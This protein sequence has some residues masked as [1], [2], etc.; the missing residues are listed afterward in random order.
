MFL[1]PCT[2]YNAI[3]Y[4]NKLHKYIVH[5]PSFASGATCATRYKDKCFLPRAPLHGGIG[6][7]FHGDDI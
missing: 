4:E 5:S 1:T 2:M 7:A 3:P 6:G